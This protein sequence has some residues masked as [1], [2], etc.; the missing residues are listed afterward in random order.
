[1][2]GSSPSVSRKDYHRDVRRLLRWVIGLLSALAVWRAWSRHRK[3]RVGAE[4][5]PDPADELRRKLAETRT[6]DEPA[7]ETGGTDEAAVESLDERRARVHAQAQETIEAM[8]EV[9][10]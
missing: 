1:V 2:Q 7:E 3:A 4:P 6:E 9:D 8:R 10:T 5:E